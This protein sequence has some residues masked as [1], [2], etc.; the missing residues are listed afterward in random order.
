MDVEGRSNKKCS[1]LGMTQ[2]A[3]R[4]PFGQRRGFL[5]TMAE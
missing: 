4:A 1:M 2:S 5:S 3:T